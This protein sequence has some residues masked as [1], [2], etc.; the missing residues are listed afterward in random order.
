MSNNS[1]T[2]Y[3]GVTDNLTRRVYEHKNKLLEG[4][5]KRYNLT[6]LVYYETTNDINAAIRREKQLKN[7]HREW[8][9][10]LI[11]SIN[12]EWRDLAEEFFG[13]N[14]T[15]DAKEDAERRDA[16][17]SSDAEINSA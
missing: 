13:E 8:K 14:E 9:I 11:E 15:K 10:N 1:R 17:P 12:K 7:W 4:F 3:I 5:T 16:K 6:K 2:L